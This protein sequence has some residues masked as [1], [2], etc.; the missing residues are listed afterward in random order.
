MSTKE[1][2]DDTLYL[3]LQVYFDDFEPNNALGG[4]AIIHKLGGIY[5]KLLC[6]P[7]YLASKLW[8]ILVAA[9]FHA[10]D[11]K[12]FTN[13]RVLKHLIK[14]LLELENFGITLETPIGSI[15]KIKIITCLVVGDNLGLQ[16]I[17]DLQIGF[18]KLYCC[19]LCTVVKGRRRNM[20]AEDITLLRRIEDYNRHYQA[21]LFGVKNACVFNK[22]PSFHIYRNIYADVMHDLLEGV[23]HYV[24]S[25]VFH[26]FIHDKER[27]NFKITDLNYRIL[28]HNFGSHNKPMLISDKYME[29]RVFVHR[30]LP[31][32][33]SEM[34]TFTRHILLLLQGL[35]PD[36]V[37]L[38]LIRK[39]RNLVSL[40]FQHRIQYTAINFMKD[41]IEDFLESYRNL[42][43]NLKPKFHYL[44]HYP[45]IFEEVGPIVNISCFSFEALHQPLKKTACS[46]N[47][48][49]N[50]PVT[51]FKK[52]E[53][54]F[55]VALLSSEENLEA[56]TSQETN[57][58]RSL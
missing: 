4:H 44:L 41:Q 25:H 47:N 49:I 30:K 9:I 7:P 23:C 53:T 13:K 1:P 56:V 52:I 26:T 32:T 27:F 36:C 10:E 22:L 33:A 51:L 6:L 35:I 29:K 19:R 5:V 38:E 24:F 18:N 21:Q 12:E 17:L 57:F 45:R 15:K 14:M 46:S 28:I 16:E 20:T 48:Q 2:S 40:F 54:K 11:R 42:Y 34:L 39:L 58:R 37:E 8:V 55:C 50:L 31:Y 3:P 43:G